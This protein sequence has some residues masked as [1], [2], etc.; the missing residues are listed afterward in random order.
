MAQIAE[1]NWGVI[2]SLLPELREIQT[3]LSKLCGPS[4]P[5]KKDIKYQ[6]FWLFDPVNLQAY[7]SVNLKQYRRYTQALTLRLEKWSQQPARDQIHSEYLYKLIEPCTY[8]LQVGE[9]SFGAQK[10]IRD[11]LGLVEE[12]R[13]SLFAQQLGKRVKVSAKMLE[14]E[15]KLIPCQLEGN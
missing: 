3:R 7:S 8:A 10:K 1:A 13:V 15:L 6:L 4:D 9:L 12:Y 5:L 11:F 14:R 2:E